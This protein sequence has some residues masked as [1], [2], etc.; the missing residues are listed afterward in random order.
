MRSIVTAL[1]CL[2]LF[3]TQLVAQPTQ[4]YSHGDP[5]PEEQLMLE[6]I[7]R[8]RANPTE[9]GI[10][11]MDTKDPAVQGAYSYFKID[12][13]KTKQAFAGYPE[14]P[15]LAFHPQLIESSRNHTTVSYTHL[16]LPTNREV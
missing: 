10:R 1:F 6:Y 8:G 14:R 15:P 2:V 4:V 16:T 3:G 12:A 11:M 13:A 9:E 7:N 5:T